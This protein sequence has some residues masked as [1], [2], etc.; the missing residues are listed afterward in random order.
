LSAPGRRTTSA[1]RIASAVVGVGLVVT[2]VW[3]LADPRSFFD[4]LATFEPYNAHFLRDIGAFQIGLGAVL[5]LGALLP[6]DGLT[7]ALL[8]VGIGSVFHAISHA[9]DGDWDPVLWVLAVAL[10]A[11]GIVT[12][13]RERPPSD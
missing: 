13:R 5:V 8:G 2:G 4:L 11:G 6:R 12:L 7:V 9:I 10:V 3:A 1:I